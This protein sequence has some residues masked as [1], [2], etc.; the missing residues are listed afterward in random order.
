MLERISAFCVCT[1]VAIKY[2]CMSAVMIMCL[3]MLRHQILV[4]ET[5]DSGILVSALD[6][7]MYACS[8]VALGV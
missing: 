2:L 4:F 1:L 3:L 5:S 7:F 8:L 6:V